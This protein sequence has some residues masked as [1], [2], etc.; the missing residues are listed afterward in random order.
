MAGRPASLTAPY[1]ALRVQWTEVARTFSL[2]PV[3][4]GVPTSHPNSA[5]CAMAPYVPPGG[6]HR[7]AYPLG[8]GPGEVIRGRW[9]TGGGGRLG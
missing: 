5:V 2:Q 4:A 8:G 7:W 9:S 3:Y 6:G 1:T